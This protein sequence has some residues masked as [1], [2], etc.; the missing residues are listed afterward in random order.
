[1]DGSV[2]VFAAAPQVIDWSHQL[3]IHILSL[4]SEFM[5]N[6]SPSETGEKQH[7]QAKENDSQRQENEAELVF[8]ELL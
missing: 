2:N 1:L 6:F 8:E 4:A 3:G 5:P 7:Q